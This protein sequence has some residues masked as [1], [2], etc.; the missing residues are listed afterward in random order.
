[1]ADASTLNRSDILCENKE[2]EEN[3]L[4]QQIQILES[5]IESEE[6]KIIQLQ[7]Q[8]NKVNRQLCYLN[9]EESVCKCLL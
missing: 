1:M 2:F 4:Y 9:R 7:D 8:I 3:Q 6:A 5:L